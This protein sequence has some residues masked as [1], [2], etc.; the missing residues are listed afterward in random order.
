MLR[1]GREQWKPRLIESSILNK[2]RVALC[3]K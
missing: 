2:R 1:I 3:G